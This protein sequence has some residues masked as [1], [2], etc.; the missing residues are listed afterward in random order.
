MNK[1]VCGLLLVCSVGMARAQYS[2]YDDWDEEYTVQALLGA[3][4]YEDLT[5]SQTDSNGQTAGV[6]LSLLPQLGGA[7]STLPTGGETLQYG[8][9]CNFLL[10]FRFDKLKYISAGGGTLEVRISTSMW[11]IDFSGGP[12][13]NLWLT[14]GLRLYAAGG[15]QLIY[16]DYRSE[17][18]ERAGATDDTYEDRD[19]VFGVG[20]YARAGLELQVH[21]RGYLGVGIRG[22]WAHADF[23]E[24][25]GQSDLTGLA[26]FV[27][28]T[29]GL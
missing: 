18:T 27:T 25:G 14:E 10:G 3:V 5:F 16:A 28:Y 22:N 24:V 12:Y 17:R 20:L 8:L 1:M 23:T 29:A 15:P 2:R 19:S 13:A 11:M 6:D 9:E 26:G 4:Q 21:D 7:W